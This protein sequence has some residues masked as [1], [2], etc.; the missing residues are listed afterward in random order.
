VRAVRGDGERGRRPARLS[1]GTPAEEG[2]DPVETD[3]EDRTLVEDYLRDRRESAFRVL[4]RRHT[5]AMYRTVLRLSRGDASLA[6]DAVQAAWIRAASGLDGFRW[7]SCLRSWLT[8]IAINCWRESWRRAGRAEIVELPDLPTAPGQ[9]RAI[10]RL[11]LQRAIDRLPDG[12]REVLLL[13]DVEGYT[14]DEIGS[15]MGIRNGTSKS[16]LSRAR[17]A[18]RRWLVRTEEE[19]GHE[20][21]AS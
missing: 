4:Y 11:D 12:Y 9:A 13:H 5:P 14:H 10:H 16:Q 15:L 3:R 8:G 7:K 1:V 2:A 19:A 20:R 18:V 21:R 17:R 6:E